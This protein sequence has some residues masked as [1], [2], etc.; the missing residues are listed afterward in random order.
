MVYLDEDR[1]EQ[2]GRAVERGRDLIDQYPRCRQRRDFTVAAHSA[3]EGL[4]VEAT[5]G[6]YAAGQGPLVSGTTVALTMAMAG[7]GAYC[8]DLAGPGA[9]TLRA[10]CSTE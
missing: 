4:R 7:R 8:D 1:S 9:A 2:S 3:I 5:D 10:R 6:P